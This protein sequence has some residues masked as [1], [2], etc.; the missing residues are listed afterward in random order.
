[1]HDKDFWLFCRHAHKY[2]IWG[3]RGVNL[4]TAESAHNDS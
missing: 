3:K 2:R 1:M 4:L